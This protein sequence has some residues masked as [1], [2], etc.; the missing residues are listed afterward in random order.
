MKKAATP[1]HTHTIGIYLHISPQMI[2]AF[3]HHPESQGSVWGGLAVESPADEEAAQS[4]RR[5]TR[6]EQRMRSWQPRPGAPG[7]PSPREKG[8]A[9]T[10]APSR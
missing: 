4:G 5:A 7:P 9:H 2:Q 8:G 6:E 3:S 1:P 10:S